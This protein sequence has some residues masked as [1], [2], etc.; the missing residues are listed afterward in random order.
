MSMQDRDP[1]LTTPVTDELIDAVKEVAAR[2]ATNPRIS[3]L[4]RGEVA[5]F[6]NAV[7]AP[8]LEDAD[9]AERL[10]LAD[11]A[12]HTGGARQVET[13]DGS[14]VVDATQAALTRELGRVIVRTATLPPIE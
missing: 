1:L 14:E 4:T 11:E 12:V 3:D 13:G 5:K 2:V 8:E 7:V 9:M 10:A 6:V